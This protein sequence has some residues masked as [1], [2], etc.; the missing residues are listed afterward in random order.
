L[1]GLFVRA[2][3]SGS[4][5]TLTAFNN[6][7]TVNHS[8][9][10]FQGNSTQNFLLANVDLAPTLLSVPFFLTDLNVKTAGF[11]SS[12]SLRNPSNYPVISSQIVWNDS[13]FQPPA[14]PNNPPNP[15]NLQNLL[16]PN[17]QEY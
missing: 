11:T 12:Y 8:D 7:N 15:N 2:K 1:N 16:T 4:N 13:N 17:P 3:S 5:S 10:E 9:V 6:V 14:Y